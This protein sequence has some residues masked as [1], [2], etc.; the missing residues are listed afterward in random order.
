M[1]EAPEKPTETPKTEETKEEEED[2]GGDFTPVVEVQEVET[3][4]MEE[5]EDVLFKM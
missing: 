5:D 2:T 3:K 1:S 4:T